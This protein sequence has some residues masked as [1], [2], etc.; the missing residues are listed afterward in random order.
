MIDWLNINN[1][2]IM[3][4]LTLV[5]VV[6]SILICIFNYKSAS[7]A[8]KQTEEAQRQFEELNRAHVIP[9]FITLEGQLFCLA[10]HN[11]GNTMAEKLNIKVSEEWL[12]CL[13]RTQKNSRVADTLLN[14]AN[15]ETFLPA[16]DKYLYSICIPA[17]GTGDYL[18][19]CEKQLIISISYQSG[20]K[21]YE[22]DFNLPMKGI[23]SIIN[24]S[25]YVRMEKKKRDSL[26][27]IEKQLKSINKSIT[28]YQNEMMI[29]EQSK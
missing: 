15:I 9:R 22:E 19:L 2:A 8:R 7:A 23:N 1:G 25:D 11:I 12:S 13:K 28:D 26:D 18:T 24:T 29:A 27:A 6:A 14:L 16:G 4:I 20:E 21:S 3:A 5:Y 10:F 17:D